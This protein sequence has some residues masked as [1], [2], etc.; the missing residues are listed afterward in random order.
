MSQKPA[1]GIAGWTKNDRSVIVYD[2]YDLWEL[3]PDGAGKPR[4][5]TDGSGEEIRHRY[6]RTT[7][8]PGGGRGGRGGG[9]GG[10]GRGRSG[11]AGPRI[12]EIRD[13]ARAPSS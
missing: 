10:R 3:F 4:R 2:A 12:S 11:R 6:A 5:L 7:P 9:R 1:Y 13:R 8:Q